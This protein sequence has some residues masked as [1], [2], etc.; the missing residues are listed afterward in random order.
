MKKNP[1]PVFS[2]KNN[3]PLNLFISDSDIFC[4]CNV[5]F[6]CNKFPNHL[7]LFPIGN[8]FPLRALFLLKHSIRIF[9]EKD[10]PGGP[11]IH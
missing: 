7:G 3:K 2:F 8:L 9:Q 6:Y 5:F 11:S 1:F 4:S 10:C